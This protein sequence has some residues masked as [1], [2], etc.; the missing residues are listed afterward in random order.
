MIRHVTVKTFEIFNK[1]I[2]GYGFRDAQL[3]QSD[4]IDIKIAA[5]LDVQQ[6][7]DQVW[8]HEA[9]IIWKEIS[10]INSTNP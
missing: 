1:L 5:I 7:F 10:S 4:E 9:L 2:P 3:H 8:Y 6:T